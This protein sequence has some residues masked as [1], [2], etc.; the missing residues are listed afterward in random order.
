MCGE[1]EQNGRRAFQ[2]FGMDVRCKKNVKQMLLIQD[3]VKK[4]VRPE[5]ETR[6]EYKEAKKMEMKTII[7][8]D[9]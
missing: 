6:R 5:E 2:Q 9:K 4:I 7:S 8:E 1:E 3:P